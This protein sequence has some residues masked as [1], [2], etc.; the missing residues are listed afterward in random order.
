MRRNFGNGIPGASVTS[1]FCAT[2]YRHVIGGSE[3]VEL[4]IDQGLLAWFGSIR[5][6][7][8][9][10]RLLVIRCAKC[11]HRL[12]VG[13]SRL[14]RDTVYVLWSSTLYR[15]ECRLRAGRGAFYVSDIAFYGASRGSQPKLL[16]CSFFVG[17]RGIPSGL[18]LDRRMVWI[19]R[20]SKRIEWHHCRR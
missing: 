15:I 19:S 17:H 20:P 10:R 8:V 2:D 4:H 13:T 7:T 11:K 6:Y 3:C 9:L 12:H 1:G 5:P 14:S 18:A 16:A